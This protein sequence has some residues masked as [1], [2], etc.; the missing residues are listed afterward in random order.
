MKASPSPTDAEAPRQEDETKPCPGCTNGTE[1]VG[2]DAFNP[3]GLRDCRTCGGT[4]RVPTEAETPRCGM[5]GHDEHEGRE[6]GKPQPGSDLTQAH[7]VCACKGVVI[8]PETLHKLDRGIADAKAER[9]VAW[10]AEDDQYWGTERLTQEGR[11]LLRAFASNPIGV[12]TLIPKGALLLL[13]AAA[14]REAAREESAPPA[15]PDVEPDMQEHE[16]EQEKRLDEMSK[17]VEF[18][19]WHGLARAFVA[20]LRA[21]RNAR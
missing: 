19:A 12:S 11:Q 3:S 20:Y 1:S 16:A 14:E 2:M 7:Y 6:C 8:D 13:L 18:S 10:S 21:E 17:C 15:A 9:V 4:S 5:C